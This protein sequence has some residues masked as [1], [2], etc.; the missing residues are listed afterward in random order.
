MNNLLELLLF[1]SSILFLSSVVDLT[2]ASSAGLPEDT[3]RVEFYN[4]HDSPIQIHLLDRNTMVRDPHSAGYSTFK[5]V[6]ALE[7]GT[8][9]SAAYETARHGD[10]FVAYDKRGIKRDVYVITADTSV[11]EQRFEIRNYNMVEAVFQNNVPGQA[12]EIFWVKPK[13]GE[14]DEEEEVFQAKVEENGRYT[15][16]THTNHKFVIYNN[17][18]REDT[19]LE[20]IVTAEAGQSQLHILQFNR[21]QLFIHNPEEETIHLFWKENNDNE[22]DEHHPVGTIH[23]GDEINI[24]SDPFHTFVAFTADQNG[25]V[26]DYVGEYIV[27]AN[28]GESQKITIGGDEF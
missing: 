12:V 15:L 1:Y 19:K 26:K 16:F 13:I 22:E 23:A 7:V 21:V 6:H 27:T 24:Q 17:N 28:R 25:E 8:D 3:V 4:A 2:K 20:L 9:A 10:V 18:N 11:K 5:D 14:E